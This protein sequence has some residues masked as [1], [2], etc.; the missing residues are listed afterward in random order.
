MKQKIEAGLAKSGKTWGEVKLGQGS[1]R[2]VEFVVQYLQLVHGGNNS[3]PGAQLQHAL[4][5]SGATGR[6]RVSTCR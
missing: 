6:L 2:D 3:P 1:I 5:R 4:R